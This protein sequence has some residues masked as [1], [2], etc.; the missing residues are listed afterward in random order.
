MLTWTVSL[1][2]L[3]YARGRTSGV[4]NATKI[5]DYSA[6][7]SCFNSHQITECEF[8]YFHRHTVFVVIVK[9]VDS[10]SSTRVQLI[11]AILYETVSES[12][13]VLRGLIC[14]CFTFQKASV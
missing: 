11:S 14:Y 9:V 7:D 1:Y 6:F 4:R 10:A 2:Q 13:V 12:A 3:A 5:F 8:R